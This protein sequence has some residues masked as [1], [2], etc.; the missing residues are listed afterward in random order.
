[1]LYEENQRSFSVSFQL[2][3]LKMFNK[4]ILSEQVFARIGGNIT[5]VNH[6]SRE[7]SREPVYKYILDSLKIVKMVEI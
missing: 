3:L 5:K 4:G 1:M 6:K 7:Q 2:F